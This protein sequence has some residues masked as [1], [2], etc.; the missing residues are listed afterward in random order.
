M[1]ST[2]ETI[3]LT[4]STSQAKKLFNAYSGQSFNQQQGLQPRLP[5]RTE[6]P[7]SGIN[8]K[9]TTQHKH[10]TPSTVMCINQI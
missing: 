10:R 4:T 8:L 9:R 5:D 6:P 2:G 7:R 1:Q 3:Q